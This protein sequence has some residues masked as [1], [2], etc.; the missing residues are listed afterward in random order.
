MDRS[1]NKGL[2][3]QTSRQHA[4]VLTSRPADTDASSR[5]ASRSRLLSDQAVELVAFRLRLFADPTR[6]RLLE[7]LNRREAN[8][9]Q[10]ADV[11][12]TTRQNVSKHLNVLYQAGVL[13]R[14]KVDSSVRYALVDW[15][16]WWLVEQVSAA[17]VD[18]LDDLRAAFDAESGER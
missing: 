7:L 13:S 1:E 18:Q 10:L 15:T 12:G 11:L 6:I 16:G 17:L 4:D 2:P 3:R 8:V 5:A 14:R 9:Q